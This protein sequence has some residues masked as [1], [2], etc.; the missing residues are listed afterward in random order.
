MFDPSAFDVSSFDGSAF[1][2]LGEEEPPTPEP[3]VGWT[4]E[5]PAVDTWTPETPL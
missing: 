4:P 2:G 5:A 3:G 1:D